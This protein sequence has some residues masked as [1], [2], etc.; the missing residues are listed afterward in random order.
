MVERSICIRDVGGSIPPFSMTDNMRGN[1]VRFPA[2]ACAK[3]GAR[4][5]LGE[6]PLA[7]AMRG[8]CFSFLCTAHSIVGSFPVV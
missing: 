3:R 7:S 5:S 1:R 8:C 6:S 2:S 4:G